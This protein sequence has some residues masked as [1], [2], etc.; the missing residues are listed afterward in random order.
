MMET[1]KVQGFLDFSLTN[2]TSK[3][4]ETTWSDTFATR[5]P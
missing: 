5:F 2:Q 4:L 3:L 1:E